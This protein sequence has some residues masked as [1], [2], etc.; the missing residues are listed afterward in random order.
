MLRDQLAAESAARLEAQV[1]S[2]LH[3]L[4][5]VFSTM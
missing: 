5:S 1:S 2:A 3:F 4:L